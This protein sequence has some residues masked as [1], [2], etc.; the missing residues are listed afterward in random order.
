MDKV[1]NAPVRPTQSAYATVVVMEASRSVGDLLRTRSQP[2]RGMLL[3]LAEQPQI[4]LREGNVLLNATGYA[5][6]YPEKATRGS[7]TGCNSKSDRGI[8][9]C[10]RTLSGLR[11]RSPLDTGCVQWRFDAVPWVESNQNC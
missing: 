1:K 3:H 11:D 4:P 5:P 10:T 8:A 9:G 6:V 7:S 2:S